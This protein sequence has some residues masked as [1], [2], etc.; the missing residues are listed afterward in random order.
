[1][2]YRWKADP[3]RNG[4]DVFTANSSQFGI[5]F[6]AYSTP[7]DLTPF[8]VSASNGSQG[9]TNSVFFW[10]GETDAHVYEV[11]QT[12]VDAL[13][14]LVFTLGTREAGMTF[15]RFIFS[16][17]PDLSQAQLDAAGNSETDVV[18]QGSN[19]T[20]VAFEA[21][22]AAA[23][24]IAGSPETW[25]STNDVTASGGTA[26]YAD[27]V[28]TTGTSPHSFAQYSLKFKVSGTYYL[29]YRWKADPARNG[30]DVFTANSSQFGTTFGAYSTPGDLTPFYVSASNG[31]QGP[32]NSV[33]FWQREAD[34][35]T[36]EVTQTDV[37][38][39]TPLVF[40]LGTREA[41][42]TFDRFIFSTVPDLSQ[43]QLDAIPN[44]GSQA[45]GVTVKKA[46]GSASLT[47]ASV[48]FS[49][50]L[51]P[52]SIQSSNFVF[53]GGVTVSAAEVDA[54][55]ST[56][57]NLTT[58]AQSQGTVY[59]ITINGISDDTG[60][61]IG[62][63]SKVNFTA[64]KLVTGWVT[65]EV[66]LNIAGGTVA[67]LTSSPSYPDYPDQVSWSKNFSINDDPLV[68][69][70]GV[71]LSAFFAPPNSSAYD[72]YLNNDDEAELQLST[73]QSAENLQSLGVFPLNAP[74]FNTTGVA[75]SSPLTANQSYLLVGLL[76]QDGGEVYLQVS[77]RPSGS[78]EDPA[79]LLAPGAA[80][81]LHPA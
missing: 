30:G 69:Q 2:Y 65:R 19:E 73:D 22:G 79:A 6:G 25:V 7:G 55:D 76:K 58:S 53:S 49:R 20:F 50:P 78:A 24:I 56:K 42:M 11:T 63:D 31:S 3:A 28:N 81:S 5:T 4:G 8:Y 62:A 39:A 23:T 36:Y 48:F 34:A 40:T 57:V 14:P 67:D 35:H 10:E 61:A 80:R 44:T 16:T 17:L 38:A 33:F 52:S 32:T 64:W 45:S 75:T 37:D 43:A 68:N 77:S 18:L 15:D 51:D 71:R 46:V 72:F 54:N 66:Y 26:L 21:D 41:G 60:S 70:Y 13:T 9:P 74:P 27:G 29:Y 59:T 47:R 1:M 12:D